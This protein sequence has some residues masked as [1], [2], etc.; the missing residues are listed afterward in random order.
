[1]IQPPQTREKFEPRLNRRRPENAMRR[2]EADSVKQEN[3]QI[4]RWLNLAKEMFES[5]KVSPRR[6][7]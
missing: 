5:D 1:M 4:N 6:K 7:A 3:A 2:L